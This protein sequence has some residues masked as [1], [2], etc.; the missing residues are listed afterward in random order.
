MTVVYVLQLF[1]IVIG[2]ITYGDSKMFNKMCT[3]IT[4][5]DKRRKMDFKLLYQL[6]Q[7]SKAEKWILSYNLLIFCIKT[8]IIVYFILLT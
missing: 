4:T 5:K 2:K 3:K 7:L 6:H 1:A 8:C